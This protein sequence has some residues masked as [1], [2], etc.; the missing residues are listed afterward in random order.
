MRISRFNEGDFLFSTP[1]FELFFAG[2]GFVYVVIRCKV[3]KPFYGILRGK[4][5]S[6]VDLVLEDTLMEISTEADIQSSG[7]TAHDV[8]A[9]IT[10]VAGHASEDCTGWSPFL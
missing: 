9:V 5:F 4:A 3:E 2:Y 10:A 6:A 1:A 8:D 7:Q